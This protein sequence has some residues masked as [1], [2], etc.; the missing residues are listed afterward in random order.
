MSVLR[1]DYSI[2]FLYE[3]LKPKL[4][5]FKAN[6]IDP[7]NKRMKLSVDNLLN[8]DA[9]NNSSA[10]HGNNNLSHTDSPHFAS[11]GHHNHN[12]HH[13]NH[14]HHHNRQHS[15]TYQNGTSRKSSNNLLSG[16]QT[17]NEYDSPTVCNYSQNGGMNNINNISNTRLSTDR[18]LNGTARNNISNNNLSTSASLLDAT[19][20]DAMSSNN[21]KHKII[22]PLLTVKCQ[23]LN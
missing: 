12:G 7:P 9:I 17:T 2:F 3:I 1:G 14:H 21:P 5:N 4:D 16:A 15:P 10:P 20:D 19:T 18:L 13:N 6:A 23:I 22:N 11:N 8:T